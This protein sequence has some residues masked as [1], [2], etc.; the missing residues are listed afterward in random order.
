MPQHGLLPWAA[1]ATRAEGQVVLQYMYL[2]AKW[3]RFSQ[4]TTFLHWISL[5]WDRSPDCYPFGR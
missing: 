3:R 4:L 1:C 5:V 2:L